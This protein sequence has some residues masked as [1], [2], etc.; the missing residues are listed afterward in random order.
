MKITENNDI[1]GL[2]IIQKKIFEI[3]NNFSLKYLLKNNL[4]FKVT[5]KTEEV[6]INTDFTIN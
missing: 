3:K 5:L 2:N 6:Y 4:N 1:I